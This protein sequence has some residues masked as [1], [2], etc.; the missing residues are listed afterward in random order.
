LFVAAITKEIFRRNLIATNACPKEW[1][2]AESLFGVFI[3]KGTHVFAPLGF[4]LLFAEKSDINYVIIFCLDAKEQKS[5]GLHLYL[6]KAFVHKA[7][8]W[9]LL[10]ITNI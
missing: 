3:L 8:V 9:L 4:G 2:V 5:Q 1:R 10:I 6:H 7:W